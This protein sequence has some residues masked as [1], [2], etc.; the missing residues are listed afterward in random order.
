[1]S[2]EQGRSEV[3]RIYEEEGFVFDAIGQESAEM[4]EPEDTAFEVGMNWK[5]KMKYSRSELKLTAGTFLP[6]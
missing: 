5:K 3:S 1:M 6:V 4:A 2:L